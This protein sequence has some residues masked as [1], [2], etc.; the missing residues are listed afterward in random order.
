MEQQKINLRK[1]SVSLQYIEMTNTLT[2][3]EKNKYEEY[4]DKHI[5]VIEGFNELLPDGS[6]IISNGIDIEKSNP[7]KIV[8]NINYHHMNEKRLLHQIYRS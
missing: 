6:G 1:L 5:E 2:D 4:Y 8:I 7:E 3:E